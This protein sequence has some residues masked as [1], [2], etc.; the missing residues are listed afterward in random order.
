AGP[1]REVE[2][3]HAVILA[4][5]RPRSFVRLLADTYLTA[6]RGLGA[7]AE[8]IDL[9]AM[10]FDPCLKAEEIPDPTEARP[11]ADVV[12]ERRRLMDADVFCLVY[13]IWFGG[14]P[15]ILKG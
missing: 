6:V 12:A 14:P 4:H 5:P 10:D 3:K 11:G 13:P 8:L 15:A 2:M 1:S 9:Y 7:E